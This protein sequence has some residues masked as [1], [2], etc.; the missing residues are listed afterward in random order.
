LRENRISK[1]GV[2]VSV[3]FIFDYLSGFFLAV[4]Y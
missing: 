4:I 1:N 2:C 3:L